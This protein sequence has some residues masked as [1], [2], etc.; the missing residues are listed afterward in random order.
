MQGKLRARP[1][2]RAEDGCE[3][4]DGPRC[5]GGCA[6]PNARRPPLSRLKRPPPE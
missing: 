4:T 2:I 1:L 3:L 5:R 6:F